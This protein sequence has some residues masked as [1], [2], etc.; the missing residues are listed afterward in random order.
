MDDVNQYAVFF[1]CHSLLAEQI[2]KTE[3]YFRIHR[4]SGGG[5]CG[6]LR[7]ETDKIYSI[8]F[9][10]QKGMMQNCQFMFY[11]IFNNIINV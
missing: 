10:C 5:D 11:I 8:A 9:K 4:R 6:P 7:R 1:E 3:N 2:K